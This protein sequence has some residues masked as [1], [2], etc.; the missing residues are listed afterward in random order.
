MTGTQ[1]RLAT[2]DA[3]N[4][5]ARLQQAAA[6]GQILLG[7]ATR[8]LAGEAAE[9]EPVEPLTLK[10][11]REPVPAWRLV[12]VSTAAPERRL[13]TPIV[14]RGSEL[15]LL[16]QAW[17][18]ARDERSCVLVTVVGSAGVGKSRLAAEFL[19][20]AQATVV[21]ARCLSYGEGITYWPVV[22]VL[23]QLDHHRSQLDPRASEALA[24]VLGERGTS[25]SDQIAWAFRKLLEAVAAEQPLIVVFD[26]IQ[27]GEDVFLDLLEQTAVMSTGV[28]LLLLCLSRPELLDRRSGWESALRLEPLDVEESRAL[29]ETRLGT[30]D[31]APEIREQI[32]SKAGGNPLFVE[33]MAAMVRASDDGA[34]DVPPTIQALLAARLDQLDA[35]ERCVLEHGS[36]EGE[37][38]HHGAVSAL[39]PDETRLMTHLTA[40]VRKDLVRPD[41]P[42]LAGDD[43]FRFRH[44]LIRD[45]AYEG[46]AKGDRA[47]L[48]ERFA[49]WLAGHGT[50]LV[51]LDE[52]VGYHLEQGYRYLEEL[53]RV[54]EHARQLARRAAE[55]LGA[56]GQRAVWREDFRAGRMLLERAR[57]LAGDA[58]SPARLEVTLNWAR[59]NTG[60]KATGIEGLSAAI[61]RASAAGDRVDELA[62]RLERG[63]FELG[64]S[65]TAD[66]LMQ[67]VEEAVPVFEA[68]GS[69]WG[70]SV[71]DGAEFIAGE[72]QGRSC[73]ELLAVAERSLTH[74]RKAE[75]PL[76]IN[77]SE[78]RVPWL[79]YL[80]ATTV[81]E[82]LR[83]LDD[84]P[85]VEAYSVLP[86]RQ[87]LLAMLGRF[88]EARALLAGVTERV[89]ELGAT[90]YREWLAL[91][92]F[93][94]ARLE[95]DWV[96]AESASRELCDLEAQ[97][98]TLNNLWF[99]CNRAEALVELGRPDEAEHWLEHG[100]AT[101]PTEEPTPQILWRQMR[102]RVLA[103]RD[104]HDEAERLAREAVA[105][106]GQTDQ[107]NLN[108]DALLALAEV[109]ALAG[110]DA[111][112]ELGQALAL[113]ERKGNLVMAERTREQLAATAA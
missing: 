50:E 97:E 6:P 70:L 78:S 87:R 13:D 53:G 28:P 110:K 100:R 82:C 113:Y 59:F 61:A 74:A 44:L 68:A 27:W 103:R 63:S 46:L 52:L 108:A 24:V 79:Q 60:E 12:A 54:D 3:V 49:D 98:V 99:C 111:G 105:Q 14:G 45:A 33:E 17:L 40:L 26:D 39:T 69:D 21:R 86:H 62:L 57:A 102:A 15:A 101:A 23:K 104:E 112:P 80:G 29:M 94:V 38:F 22:E 107:L 32:L 85:H 42:Q 83:W 35:N 84:H 11:K 19:A 71:A 93:E 109:L 1:E 36:V 56:A 90:R 48:H 20:G 95:R 64:T 31:L 8:G 66:E 10:G 37:L 106:A 4:I 92:R 47:D 72:L 41:R 7:E 88:G 75:D 76:W 16:E 9:A 55:R 5:A 65:V 91:R 89:E 81:D 43:A 51:E 18:R 73:S 96:E 67:L 58:R 34:V 77:W 25:S 2:G 30:I